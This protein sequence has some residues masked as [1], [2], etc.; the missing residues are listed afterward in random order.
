MA[1]RRSDSSDSDYPWWIEPVAY[2]CGVVGVLLLYL[3]GC[4]IVFSIKGCRA[5][6]KAKKDRESQEGD[7]ETLEGEDV[8]RKDSFESIELQEVG[9]PVPP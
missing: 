1:S 2:L 6:R 7:P 3:L 4:F 5:K 9:V 8:G